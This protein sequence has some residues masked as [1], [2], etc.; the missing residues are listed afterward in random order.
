VPASLNLGSVEVNK[1]VK[2]TLKVTNKGTSTL[3]VTNVEV[4]GRDAAV[5]KPSATR[6]NVER[7]KTYELKVAF[8]PTS[9]RYYSA[10]LRI[11]SNDSDSPIKAIALTGRGVDD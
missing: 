4:I 2:K 8:K 7:S 6:F 9:R 3:T 10:T 5:F 1:T 11:Y